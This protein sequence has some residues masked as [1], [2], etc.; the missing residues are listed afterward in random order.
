VWFW[1]IWQ[2]SNYL[3]KLTAQ[4]WFSRR[5]DYT[6]YILYSLAVI[7][8]GKLCILGE[9]YRQCKAYESMLLK[10]YT[11]CMLKLFL[12]EK[13]GG[14]GF[15]IA[16]TRSDD[17]AIACF[18]DGKEYHQS[19]PSK[20]WQDL[21]FLK[22]DYDYLYRKTS[23]KVFRWLNQLSG[24]AQSRYYRIVSMTRAL[25]LVIIRFLHS[26]VFGRTASPCS[27][28]NIFLSIVFK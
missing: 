18:L 10:S 4:N 24:I 25:N 16:W 6:N 9:L 26:F 21:R 5:P 3:A 11:C 27:H 19:V 17:I 23:T 20:K 28:I 7:V 14:H 13:V 1:Y 15:P 22:N 12:L 2:W 8:T